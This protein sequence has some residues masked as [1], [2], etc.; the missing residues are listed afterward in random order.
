M[1]EQSGNMLK[2]ITKNEKS[3]KLLKTE[4]NDKAATCVEY[5]INKMVVDS[6][7]EIYPNLK[8]MTKR[9]DT[10]EL[11]TK[12]MFGQ[13]EMKQGIPKNALIKEGFLEK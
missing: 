11:E 13:M 6:L 3:I 12:E 4:D 8:V 2:Y 9:H 10:P 5:A 1:L 7:K